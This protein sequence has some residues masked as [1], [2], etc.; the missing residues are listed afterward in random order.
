MTGGD[1]PMTTLDYGL[2]APFGARC[3]MTQFYSALD[4]GG[5]SGLN[6]P[7]GARCFMTERC[8]GEERPDPRV[9]LHRLALGAI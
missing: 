5:V 9:L 8:R 3:F 7:F 2:N 4:G 1:R 6:A